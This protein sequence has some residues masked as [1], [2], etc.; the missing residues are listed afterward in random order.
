M[1]YRC[2][3]KGSITIAAGTTIYK[4]QRTCTSNRRGSSRKLIGASQCVPHPNPSGKRQN[5]LRWLKRPEKSKNSQRMCQ[6]G[7][8]STLPCPREAAWN[9][10]PTKDVHSPMVSIYIR[11]GTPQA[12]VEIANKAAQP[13]GSKQHREIYEYGYPRRECPK[14]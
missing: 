5:N 1:K 12:E 4:K 9:A 7:A 11:R 2:G 13:P 6:R 10:T 8:R 14:K 3:M